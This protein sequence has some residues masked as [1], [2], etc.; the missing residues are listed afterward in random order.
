MEHQAETREKKRAQF[1]DNEKTKSK[2]TLLL[3]AAF[4]ALAAVAAYAVISSL[5][6]KPAATAITGSNISNSAAADIRIPL[7]ELNSGKA[8]FFEHTLS[9]NKRIRFFAIKSS[10]GVYRAAMDACDTCYQA[11]QGYRQEGDV[12]VCN[13][14]GLTFHSTLINEVAGGC[15]PV[16]LPR[17][18]ESDHLL[19][20]VSELESRSRY[21]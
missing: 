18:V 14:C 11:K 19:I 6:D 13:K 3:V 1:A 20:K 12:M 17:T 10:D 4:L 7:A 21:F 8:K 5:S 16:G 9:D 15:N 2:T